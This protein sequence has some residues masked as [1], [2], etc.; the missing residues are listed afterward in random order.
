MFYLNYFNSRGGLDFIRLA[1]RHTGGARPNIALPS[2][3]CNYFTGGIYTN[4]SYPHYIYVPYRVSE[5]VC[6]P[7]NISIP[8]CLSSQFS[9]CAMAYF[10]Y[11]RL[12]AFIAHISL[13]STTP[14]AKAVWNNFIKTEQR[15]ISRYIIFKPYRHDTAMSN[16]VMRCANYLDYYCIGLI[17]PDFDCFSLLVHKEKPMLNIPMTLISYEKVTPPF[18]HRSDNL[19]YESSLKRFFIPKHPNRTRW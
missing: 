12:G 4:G 16:F 9:G 13:E 17:T 10:E 19:K 15:N 11:D 14:D 18:C 3:L 6:A 2:P 8:L 7:V 1:E 5:V